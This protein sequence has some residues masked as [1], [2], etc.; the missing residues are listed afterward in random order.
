MTRKIPLFLLFLL[1]LPA[2]VFAQ[3]TFINPTSGIISSPFGWRIHPITGASRFHSGIDIADDYY[4]PVVASAPGVVTHAGWIDGYGNAV[5]I[6][7]EGGWSTLYGHFAEIHVMAGQTVSTGHLIGGQGS[8]GNSTGPHCHFEIRDPSGTPVDPALFVPE[9]G[10]AVSPHG[11]AD[12]EGQYK[13]WTLTND[14]AKPIKEVMDKLVEVITKGLDLLQNGVASLF[15]ILCLIDIALGAMSKVLTPPSEDKEGLMPWIIRR[16]LFYGFCL[17]F[18]YNWSDFIGNLALYG[19]PQLGGLV[20]GDPAA[21]EAAVSDPTQ[22]VQKGMSIVAPVVNATLRARGS[23]LDLILGNLMSVVCILCAV[24]LFFL[25]CVIGFYIALAYIQF[26]AS[27]LFSFTTFPLAGLKHVRH[28]ASNGISGVIACSINLMFFCFFSAALQ[29]S[30]ENITIPALV[31]TSSVATASAPRSSTPATPGTGTSTGTGT[32]AGTSTGTGTTTGTSTGAS[33]ATGVVDISDRPYAHIAIAISQRT[34]IRADFIYAQLALES[35]HF[36]SDVAIADHNYG[37]VKWI[38]YGIRGSISDDGDY[39]RHFDSDEE[40]IEY[41]SMNLLAYT[42][43]GIKE[44]QTP[45]EYAAALKRGGYYEA[46]EEHYTSLIAGIL[47]MDPGASIGRAQTV[48]NV[49]LML[50]VILLVLLFMFMA[51][52]V[53]KLVI[54]QFGSGGFHLTDD[55]GIFSR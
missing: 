10:G 44:A 48:V 36:Q 31:T 38:G 52:R 51:D 32:T 18:L 8:T 37:G 15:L 50:Q 17:F 41:Q 6:E 25:F 35:S 19:F 47:D 20:G 42:D 40:F 24:V 34:G 14:F 54:E 29:A 46:T 43:D 2:V 9:L 16:S 12:F 7:H 33:P 53:S 23:I 45:A 13:D 22:I 26:Y 28:F 1:L 5:I 21:A 49:F 11:G 3:P 30:L 27:V 4:T 39:Y 55:E